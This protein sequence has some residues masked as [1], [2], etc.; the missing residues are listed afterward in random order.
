MRRG[1]RYLQDI[2]LIAVAG[3]VAAQ[4]LLS[5]APLTP[6]TQK[7]VFGSKIVICSSHGLMTL[8]EDG[9]PVPLPPGSKPLCPWCLINAAG[10]WTISGLHLLTLAVLQPPMLLHARMQTDASVPASPLFQRVASSPRAPP[11]R[12]VA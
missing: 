8:D 1:R 7:T 9:S 2:V 5:A 3:F 4:F 10:D 6:S 11:A 12:A